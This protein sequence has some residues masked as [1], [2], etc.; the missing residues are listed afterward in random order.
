[1]CVCA[2]ARAPTLH[3]SLHVCDSSHKFSVPVVTKTVYFSLRRATAVKIYDMASALYYFHGLHLILR[4]LSK[5]S[6]MVLI[7]SYE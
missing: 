5:L 6:N 2:R 4:G 7:N 3:T 1:V